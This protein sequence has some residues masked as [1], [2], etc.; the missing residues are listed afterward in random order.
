VELTSNKPDRTA[1]V[2]VQL[3]NQ[4][5]HEET[6]PDAATLAAMVRV[7]GEVLATPAACADLTAELLSEGLQFPLVLTSEKKLKVKFTVTFSTACIPD[8]LRSTQAAAHADYRFR[9]EV[10]HSA[11]DGK[12]GTDPIDDVCPRAGERIDPNPDGSLKDKGCGAKLPDHSVGAAVLTDV[13][14]KEG[15]AGE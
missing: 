9:A 15:K 10:D 7:R 1:K 6:I 3:Q 14:L 4:S 13:V 12:A 5:P 8:P 11:L 2:S